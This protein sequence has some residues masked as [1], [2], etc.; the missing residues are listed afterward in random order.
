MSAQPLVGVYLDPADA[1]LLVRLI[2]DYSSHLRGSVDGRA[3]GNRVVALRAELDRANARVSARPTNVSSNVSP[4]GAQRDTAQIDVYAFID[5]RQAAA[6]LGISPSGV[7]DLAR[8]GRLVSRKAGGRWVYSLADAER[9]AAER[10]HGLR[11]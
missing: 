9:I 3:L 10:A 4:V 11:R 6:V 5:S 8:R 1:G 2:D 7:R